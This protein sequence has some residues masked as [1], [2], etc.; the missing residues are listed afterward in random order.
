MV[1]SPLFCLWISYS[2][3]FQPHTASLTLRPHYIFSIFTYTESPS[4]ANSCLVPTNLSCTFLTECFFFWNT[5]LSYYSALES[6][7]PVKQ[8]LLSKVQMTCSLQNK[9]CFFTLCHVASAT[10]WGYLKCSCLCP[11]SSNRYL[12]F[13]RLKMSTATFGGLRWISRILLLLLK[14][15][16]YFPSLHV[17]KAP[18]LSQQIDG[19]E[20]RPC[21]PWLGHKKTI[22]H[23]PGF[24]S[25]GGYL[26]LD[27]GHKLQSSP[28]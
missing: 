26:P 7:A 11:L 21:S 4:R 17:Y 24:I 16:A 23:L 18:W 9:L 25:L 12:F 1:F 5:N 10:F 13:F 22:L 27:T 6:Y 19:I 14:D 20:V 2:S 3:P 15:R 8:L 28:K